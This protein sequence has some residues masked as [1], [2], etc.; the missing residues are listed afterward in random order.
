MEENRKRGSTQLSHSQVLRSKIAMVM[1]RLHEQLYQ[2]WNHPRIGD[3]FPKHLEILYHTVHASVPLLEAALSEAQR[4][5]LTCPVARALI[6]Y[7]EKHIA[8]EKDHDVW[9]LEDLAVFGIDRKSVIEQ[10]PPSVVATQIGSQ[11]YYIK[12]A[13]PLAVIAYLA[14]VE[15]SPPMADQLDRLVTNTAIPREAMRSFYKHADIDRYHSQELWAFI[16]TLPLT[17][18]QTNL[19]GLNS[20]L[21]TEHAANTL[22]YLLEDF[23]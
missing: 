7:L 8:E 13:H 12:Y 17:H 9:V 6:P 1:P 5:E 23:S 22:E 19:L 18:K 2:F 11:Y 16:D 21:T 20:M 4:L 15:G 10:I 3:I 14:V